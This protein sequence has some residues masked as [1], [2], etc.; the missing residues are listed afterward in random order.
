MRT[1]YPVCHPCAQNV[2]KEFQALENRPSSQS[3]LFPEST[4]NML[5][6]RQRQ[7][8]LT[9]VRFMCN[10]DRERHSAERVWFR[11]AKGAVLSSKGRE[12]NSAGV[13][14]EKALFLASAPLPSLNDSTTKRMLSD[15]QRKQTGLYR[16]R[17]SLKYAG[18][19]P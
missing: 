5:H 8:R 13:T 17:W 14:T 7:P 2:T 12:F 19:K 11:H 4:S 6:V 18:S 10:S 1:L 15:D 9:E 16:R 3:S